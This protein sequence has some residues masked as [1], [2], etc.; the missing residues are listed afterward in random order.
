MSAFL[1]KTL[2]SALTIAAVTEVAKRNNT[3]ASII[4]SLPLTSLLAFVWLYLE[5][6]DSSLIGRHAF[7]TFW[8]VLPTLPMFL[9]M[10]QLIRHCGGVW[11]ALTRQLCTF[12][13]THLNLNPNPPCPTKPAPKPSA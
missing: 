4:H 9:L 2:I 11:P 8:M 1:I 13:E 3:A 7:G 6:K 12:I 5:T 10:P